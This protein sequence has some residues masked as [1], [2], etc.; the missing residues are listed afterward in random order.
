MAKSIVFSILMMVPTAK[1]EFALHA[2]HACVLPLN[3]AGIQLLYNIMFNSQQNTHIH[4]NLNFYS[5]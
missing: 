5:V 2:Y 3:Y 1:I 4:C